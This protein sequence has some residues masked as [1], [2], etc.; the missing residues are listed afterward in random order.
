MPVA[1]AF[2]LAMT[3]AQP[4]QEAIDPALR[5]AVERFYAALMDWAGV[6][7]PLKATGDR[8]EARL[9][10]TPTG[11]LVFVFN[12]NAKPT[13]TTLTLPPG[14]LTDLVTAQSVGSPNKT[15]QPNEVWVLRIA[16]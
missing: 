11:P 13:E 4:A 1:A 14:K 2:V 10:D 5:A 9:L 6:V 3:A 8:I 7:A 16:R 15:L 12:H